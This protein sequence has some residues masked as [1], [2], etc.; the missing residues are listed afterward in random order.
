VNKTRLR[1]HLQV[2]IDMAKANHSALIDSRGITVD[3]AEYL[4][5]LIAAEMAV[6]AG[7]PMCKDCGTEHWWID[8]CPK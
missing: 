8:G 3:E 5:V 2:Q 1:E 4:C 6:A 7:A